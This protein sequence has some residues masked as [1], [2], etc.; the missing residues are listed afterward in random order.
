MSGAIDNNDLLYTGENSSIDYFRNKA[1]D[2]QIVLNNLDIIDKSLMDVRYEI[3]GQDDL[4]AEWAD[5]Y[6]ELQS[7]K[8]QFKLAAEAINLASN[9]LNAVNIRFPQLSI[10]NSLGIAPAIGV[11]AAIAGAAVLVYWASEFIPRVF[12]FFDYALSLNFA[13][14]ETKK[15]IIELK[16]KT[17]F[18]IQRNGS[19]SLNQ[20][21]NV[22]KYVAFA[23]AAYFAYKL[24]IG[25]QNG[26]NR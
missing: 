16:E 12:N 8:S 3:N 22:I 10:P 23:G 15:R 2:F 20:V 24:F 26:N 1:R 9:G 6:D 21:V 14:E 4:L 7:K 18:E 5:L 13:D 11:A 25:Y 17:N 19:G